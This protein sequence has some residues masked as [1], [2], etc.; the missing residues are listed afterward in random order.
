M[1]IPDIAALSPE[2]VAEHTWNVWKEWRLSQGF[3]LG[4]VAPGL[5]I[6]DVINKRSPHLVE[7]WGLVSTTGQD[8]FAQMVALVLG[9]IQTMQPPKKVVAPPSPRKVLQKLMKA[10]QENSPDVDVHLSAFLAVSPDAYR[11]LTETARDAW[12]KQNKNATK[13]SLM[14]VWEALK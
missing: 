8:A 7:E 4:G 12:A 1:N 2:V 3:R 11:G 14:S 5:P 10:L 9:G 13:K 6:E